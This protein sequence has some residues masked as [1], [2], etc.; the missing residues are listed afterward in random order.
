[1]LDG[2]PLSVLA[3]IAGAMRGRKD[4]WSGH[5]WEDTIGR[6]Q[7]ARPGPHGSD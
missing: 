5:I 7:T 4:A 6:Q 3:I 2:S 1:M